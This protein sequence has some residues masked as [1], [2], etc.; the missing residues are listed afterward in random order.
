MNLVPKDPITGVK[1]AYISTNNLQSYYL[2]A[3]LERGSSDAKAC[4]AGGWCAS[5]SSGAQ[6]LNP[7]GTGKICNYGVSSPDV[8]P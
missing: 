7:C 1:Y 5:I 2:Y 8:S 4:A 3:S 6:S